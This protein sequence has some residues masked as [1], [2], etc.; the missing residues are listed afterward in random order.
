MADK[1]GRRRAPSAGPRPFAKGGTPGIKPVIAGRRMTG[2]IVELSYGT[3]SGFVRAA[4]GQRVFFHRA[5]VEDGVLFNELENGDA[6]VFEMVEDQFSGLRALG[7][8]AL[9]S[10]GE[11]GAH[12]PALRRVTITAGRSRGA[13]PRRPFTR[14]E[15]DGGLPDAL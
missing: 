15:I 9:P 13:K 6:V 11:R 7:C 8:G 1:P 5:D 2:R 4:E 3:S 10:D 12:D 14:Q